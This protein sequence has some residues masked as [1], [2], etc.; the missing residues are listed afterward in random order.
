MALVAT[1]FDERRQ[2]RS[3][4]TGEQVTVANIASLTSHLNC[5]VCLN[6]LRE[7]VLVRD[8]FCGYKKNYLKKKKLIKSFLQ[9]KA[10]LHRFCTECINRSLHT[11]KR[12]CPSC[13][14]KCATKRDL[15]P[16]PRFDALVA[17]L[18][19][20]ITRFESER[21]VVVNKVNEDAAYRSV[22]DKM[23]DGLRKQA[24]SRAA[25]K[26]ISAAV[27][28][29]LRQK[30]LKAARESKRQRA[31]EEAAAAAAAAAAGAAGAAGGL[32]GDEM[33]HAQAPSVAKRG[34]PFKIESR[35][36]M[37]KINKAVSK[38]KRPQDQEIGFYFFQHPEGEKVGDLAKPRITVSTQIR[39]RH[40][41]QFVASKLARTES[42]Q[43]VQLSV[44]QDGVTIPLA[45]EMTLEDVFFK[46]WS[47]ELGGDFRLFYGLKNRTAR[48]LGE[49]ME[50]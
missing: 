44:I 48:R 4:I 3:L 32:A 15:R 10:C 20:D 40:L 29:V 39:V 47:R 11:G 34:R 35:P 28:S 36:I 45:R 23:K 22:V 38:P 7:T 12:E 13:R 37:I 27:N 14:A 16:D 5:P 43:K 18:L 8:D 49:S 30:R 41:A 50:M 26:G 6:I 24:L 17:T 42:A 19:T 33:A 2:V 46:W 25:G 21:D 31:S 1:E 9:V